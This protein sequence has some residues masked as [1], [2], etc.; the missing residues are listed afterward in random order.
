MALRRN[1]LSLPLR[2]QL[3]DSRR[4][5]IEPDKSPSAAPGLGLPAYLL[6]L[7]VFAPL[8]LW[9]AS[10][11]DSVWVDEFH[12]LFMA[13]RPWDEVLALAR[14][15][16]H[17]PGFY[18]LLHCWLNLGSWL[19]I[20]P[21]ILW[22][23]LPG[24]IAWL[25]FSAVCWWGG[26][27]VLGSRPGAIFAWVLAGSAMLAI[28]ARDVRHYAFAVPLI[29]SCGLI[30]LRI[31]RLEIE[32]QLSRRRG[33]FLWSAYGFL[34]GIAMWMHLLSAIMLLL[35]GLLWLGMV[36]WRRRALLS[37]FVIGGAL[38]QALAVI[39]FL[40]WATGIA[41]NMGFQSR[42]E[43][44]WIT[45]TTFGNWL[46]VFFY[47]FPLGRPPEASLPFGHPL[48]MALGA[49]TALPIVAALLRRWISPPP[50]NGHLIE[51]ALPLLLAYAFVSMLWLINRF[52]L[53]K[54]FHGPRYTL[55]ALP[56]WA[57]GLVGC[58]RYAA[59]DLR[60]SHLV[61]LLLLAPWLA[62]SGL[63]LAISLLQERTHMRRLFEEH[64]ALLPP[65][66]SQLCIL[67]IKATPYLDELFPQ[68]QLVSLEEML[69]REDG[70]QE[71]DFYTMGAWKQFHSRGSRALIAAMERGQLPVS[72]R[73]ILIPPDAWIASEVFYRIGNPRME[74]VRRFAS[75]SGHKPRPEFEHAVAI[76]LPDDQLVI[77][78]FDIPELSGDD[79]TF[80]WAAQDP[81]TVEFDR[82]VPAGH[83]TLK[84]HIFRH[85][86][87]FAEVEMSIRVKGEPTQ[88]TWRQPQGEAL[89][90]IPLVI[91]KDQ[92][93]LQLEVSHP[94][95]SPMAAWP[96]NPDF[97]LLTFL[98]N[99][100]WIE[101]APS[102]AAPSP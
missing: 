81:V 28:T 67:P 98:F 64:R 99:C 96:G 46:G 65:P 33:A 44:W 17:P 22:A 51:T 9:R 7:I 32:G 8:A 74:V 48:V 2:P 23:R 35:H 3:D 11:Q 55:F 68:Y 45:P 63:S 95:W 82:P 83:Y 53:G 52:E 79:S 16:A 78:G 59:Q 20:P 12:S 14:F 19:G 75:G 102:A 54:V 80:A 101:P 38:A 13:M 21:T 87:P 60:R 57:F 76:A 1:V 56:L 89:V 42:M 26:R 100:A 31:I 58:A 4:A 85:P 84:M 27:A 91:D 50:P 24:F 97:R 43:T 29:G 72:T 93:K 70:V 90:S 86:Q 49:L 77:N 18:L 94:G 37:P 71:I 92:R 6:F 30:M 62:G 36:A 25:L 10:W 15:D 39:S 41:E 5:M 73:R 69:A 47:W 88:H 66:G 61:T 40:P 34:A